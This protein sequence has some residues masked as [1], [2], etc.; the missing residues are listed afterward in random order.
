[1]RTPFGGRLHRRPWP[2]GCRRE[3]NAAGRQPA[4]K[5]SLPEVFAPNCS[6]WPFVGRN[7]RPA[8]LGDAHGPLKKP[9]H[10]LPRSA[11]GRR[12]VASNAHGHLV[13]RAVKSPDGGPLFEGMTAFPGG[14][15]FS[16]GRFSGGRS[17][18]APAPCV[19]PRTLGEP[20]AGGD[21]HWPPRRAR[22]GVRAPPS[23]P[24]RPSRVPPLPASASRR[25]PSPRPGADVRLQPAR[26]S[27][28]PRKA[29]LQ[30][31]P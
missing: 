29:G 25:G 4:P 9:R 17:Q 8:R 10:Y 20:T 6:R 14:P 28:P 18:I 22:G 26:S 16:P 5:P 12:S 13:R 7:F 27:L 23:R 30:L 2:R 24:R 11:Q 21:K 3:K 1:M 31:L 19:C 15:K